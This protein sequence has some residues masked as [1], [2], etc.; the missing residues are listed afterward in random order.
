M[1]NHVIHVKS[2]HSCQIMS[3]MSNHVIHVKSCQIMS[4]MS[5]HAIHDFSRN[6]VKS[7]GREGGGVKYV[8]LNPK[9]SATALL[10]GQRQKWQNSA[11]FTSWTRP[12]CLIRQKWMQNI[13]NSR[14]YHMILSPHRTRLPFDK[15]NPPSASLRPSF[16]KNRIIIPKS[17][18]LQ[19]QW[20]P[21]TSSPP[22]V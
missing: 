20:P 15:S 21:R 4:F 6:S 2:C 16:H 19:R 5:N 14:G 9:P 22:L 7:G 11:S 13:A 17:D 10:S 3:F 12:F 8:F 1:S 18:P